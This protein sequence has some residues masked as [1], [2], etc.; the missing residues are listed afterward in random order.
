MIANLNDAY[1]NNTL[2]YWC[3]ALGE[4][5]YPGDG[6]NSSDVERLPAKVKELYE[7]FQFSSREGNDLNVYTVTYNG[8]DGML[9]ME[10]QFSEDVIEEVVGGNAKEMLKGVLSSTAKE[11]ATQCAP[12]GSVLLCFDSAPD[13]HE[14]GVFIPADACSTHYHEVAKWLCDSSRIV[15]LRTAIATNEHAFRLAFSLLMA[16]GL[17]QFLGKSEDEIEKVLRPSGFGGDALASVAKTIILLANS[18]DDEIFSA[19][20]KSSSVDSESSDESDMEDT[21]PLCGAEVEYLGDRDLDDDGTHVSWAC[22]Y[23]KAT[24]VS[25]Y[26]DKFLFHSD[27][28]DAEGKLVVEEVH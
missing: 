28:R 8:V 4:I 7:C 25:Q 3:N 22:P 14:L 20:Q 21:C 27:V 24:G 13:G 11:L 1:K 6:I 16:E 10:D 19:I 23:C 5:N 2:Y 26:E 17:R 12:W 15:T 9:L 18:E